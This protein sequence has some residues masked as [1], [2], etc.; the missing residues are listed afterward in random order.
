MLVRGRLP[1]GTGA[2]T[3]LGVRALWVYPA[4]QDC[5]MSET[6]NGADRPEGETLLYNCRSGA[7]NSS[8]EK[9]K[10]PQTHRT[11]RGRKPFVEAESSSQSAVDPISD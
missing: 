11:K 10:R 6:R 3:S 4:Q 2:K 5:P 8:S 1:K 9:P 7:Q